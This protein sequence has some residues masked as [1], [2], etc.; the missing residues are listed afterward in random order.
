VAGVG[1]A[2]SVR[3]AAPLVARCLAGLCDLGVDLLSPT[4]PERLAGI[5]AF[6][7]PEA[8]LVHRHLHARGIHVMHHAGRLRVAIHGYTTDDDVETFLRE[9]ATAL[10]RR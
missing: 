8:E 3:H 7:H 4:E 6:R 1:L 10:A 2:A 9:L 5:L